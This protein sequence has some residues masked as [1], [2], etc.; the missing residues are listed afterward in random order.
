MK[1]RSLG[2]LALARLRYNSIGEKDS[3][4]YE[5]FL[6]FKDVSAKRQNMPY[7]GGW[8]GPTSRRPPQELRMDVWK[9]SSRLHFA[10]C[11]QSC[12]QKQLFS[13]LYSVTML[14]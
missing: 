11:S 5:L 12:A 14:A 1:Y 10:V 7:D 9:G 3:S 4:S 8:P 13:A 6:F 2:R